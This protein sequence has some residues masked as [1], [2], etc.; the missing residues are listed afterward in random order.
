MIDLP[1]P[2]RIRLERAERDWLNKQAI[3]HHYMHRAVHPRS[4]PLG[5]RLIFDGESRGNGTPCGFITFASI[6][7]VKQRDLFG[8]PSLPTKWQV[9]SLARFWLADTLPKN[10]ATA[11]LGKLLR[12]QGEEKI[13][14]VGRGWLGVHPPRFPDDPYHIRLIISYADKTHGHEGTIYKAA[15][16]ERVKET[17]S[18][19]RHTNTRGP[20]LD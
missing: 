10:T 1:L 3:K 9:L 14:R 6:H 18:Q 17:K 20:G 15:N 16:F 11:V 5:Y 7:F 8:Y 4:F 2:Q 19:R 13:C 12:V